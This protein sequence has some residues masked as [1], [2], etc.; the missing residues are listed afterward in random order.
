ML[1]LWVFV[2]VLVPAIFFFGY[3]AQNWAER[4]ADAANCEACECFHRRGC[5][6]GRTKG[7]F[8]TN[9]YKS[10]WF[11]L[12]LGTPIILLDVLFYASLATEAIRIIVRAIR[13]SSVSAAALLAFAVLVY[14]NF[15]CFWSIY[16]YVNDRN[17]SLI[18]NQLFFCATEVAAAWM[19]CLLMDARAKPRPH[20]ETA[21]SVAAGVAASHLALALLDQL[22]DR[23]LIVAPL[24]HQRLRD[25]FL[26]LPEVVLLLL[27]ARR[28]RAR[29]IAKLV[30]VLVPVAL[31]WFWLQ[32]V[33][34]L[35][36]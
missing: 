25:A 12:D 7:S 18:D 29:S 4:S 28:Q 6:D 21:R 34:W 9:G 16:T 30:A 35:L 2:V 24:S 10:L 5:W 11:N 3:G 36:S 32:P 1:L 15:Y 13:S 23:Y 19:C 31:V 17:W 22:R 8:P 20:D 27:F 33:R 14:P 26:L